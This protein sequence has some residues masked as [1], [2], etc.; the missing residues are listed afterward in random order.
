MA[1]VIQKCKVAF[2]ATVFSVLLTITVI[3]S[4]SAHWGEEDNDC[5]SEHGLTH[6]YATY[7]T[8]PNITI[9][10]VDNELAW[11]LTNVYEYT[12]PMSNNIVEATSP[13]ITYMFMKYIY[14]GSYLYI[15]A[16][17][18]DSSINIHDMALFCW[19]INCTNYSASMFA[20]LNAMRTANPGEHVDSWQ[21]VY[22]NREN[23][24][25]N[26][27]LD[28]AFD[29]DGWLPDETSREVNYG[30][31]HGTLRNDSKH[32]Y[33]L[34]MRRPLATSQPSVD[35]TFEE[36]VPQ[37]FTTGVCNGL[38]NQEHA[39]SWTYDLNL[40]HNPQPDTYKPRTPATPAIGAADHVLLLATI[41]ATTVAVL[42]TIKRKLKREA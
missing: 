7:I 18:N 5:L 32:Y 9:D 20:D 14:D 33:Q 22:N 30:F 4:T 3:N 27:L 26:S 35:V 34:E 25:T 13:F 6:H 1:H 28:A 38:E 37:R 8:Y 16:T 24:S 42:A 40:T 41:S 39:I 10:G 17:W 12:I 15:R 2:I 31:V 36:N 23:G 29:Y 11:N 19:D 21:F